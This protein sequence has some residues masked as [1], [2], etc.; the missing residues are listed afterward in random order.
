MDARR[1]RIGE[2]PRRRQ[3]GH[4]LAVTVGAERLAVAGLTEIAGRG[5]AGA[6]LAQPVTVVREVALRQEARVLETAVTCVAAARVAGGV[7][8]VTAKAGRH[9]RAQVVVAVGDADMAAHAIAAGRRG[10]LPVIEHEVI[11][12][13]GELGQR[14]RG[15]V[16]AE[17]RPLAVG[18]GMTGR[19]RGV[20]RKVQGARRG[21]DA[22]V[23]ARA[24][25]PGGRVLAMRKRLRLAAREPEHTGARGERQAGDDEAA[26]PHREPQRRPS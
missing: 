4:G 19:A 2:P 23:A 22:R 3:R 8:S 18:P 21:F 10:V 15:R 11:A 9:R 13:F 5:R 14:A 26:P 7:V 1:E 20:V 16:T 17:A 6:V 25:D 24:G 12:R